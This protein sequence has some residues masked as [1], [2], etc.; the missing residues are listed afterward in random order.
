MIPFGTMFSYGPVS[1]DQNGYTIQCETSSTLKLTGIL[2]L[3]V[4]SRPGP[5]DIGYTVKGIYGA[6]TCMHGG[7]LIGPV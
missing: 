5:R 2:Q 4:V 3:N 1:M 7:G 6:Y